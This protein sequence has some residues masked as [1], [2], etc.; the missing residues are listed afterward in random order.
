MLFHSYI[1]KL[2]KGAVVPGEVSMGVAKAGHEGA[3][4][5]L[6]D[7][8]SLVLLR[9]VYFRNTAHMDNSFSYSMRDSLLRN[10]QV[11]ISVN[12]QC[13]HLHEM[14]LHQLSRECSHL[15]KVS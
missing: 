7:S 2:I 13:I 3:T 8:H 11:V 10:T 12:L 14:D 9:L 5:T 6:D 1:S 4:A 15:R